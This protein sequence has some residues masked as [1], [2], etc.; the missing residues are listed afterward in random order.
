MLHKVKYIFLI[1]AILLG[2]SAGAQDYVADNM[3]VYQRNVGGWPKHI[4]DVK[5]DYTKKLSESEKAT[6][7][8]DFA[9]ND[10]TI[11]NNATTKEI[12]YLVTAFK[13][14]NNKGYLEAAEKGIRYLLKMQYPNGGFPQFYPDSS[15]YRSQVTFNDNAMINALN[16]L[17]DVIHRAN[18]FEVVS[19]SLIEPAKTAV[20][21]GI[22]C[23][24]K[25]QINVNGNLT[26]WG[27]QYDKRTLKPAK[28][29]I[30]ELP[31][32]ASM[33][34]VEIV[35]FLMKIDKPGKQIQTA[36]NCAV[37]WLQRSKIDGY[38]F[39]DVSDSTQPKG[40][41]R[42]LVLDNNSAVW[43][44]F[45]DI[46][47][48]KPLFAGRD[49]VKRWNLSDIEVERRT[50][51]GWYGKWPKNLLD[52]EY[53]RWV[54]KN[55]S[56]SASRIITVDK[57]GR[58]NFRSIQSAINSLPASIKQPVIIKIGNGVYNEK[59][60]LQKS[61][62]VLQGESREKTIITYAIARDEWRCT[63]PSDWGVATI[64]IAAN[65]ITFK[66][67][68]IINSYGLDNNRDRIIVCPL[69]SIN[70]KRTITKNGHQM[71]LRSMDSSTRL[72]AINV[73]FR[74]YAGDTVSPW[75]TDNGMFYFKDCIMEGGVDFYCPRGW[76]YAE[77]CTFISHTGTAA[78]WHDGSKYE[79]S[80]TV[81]KNCSFKGFDGFNL[82]RYHRDAQFYLIDCSFAKNM[83]DKDIYLV[84]TSNII[85]WGKRVYYSNCKKD[86]GDY[87]WHK[88]NLNSAKGSPSA[89]NINVDWVFKNKWYPET[90]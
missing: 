7:A 39:I 5:V 42:I 73:H 21:K 31:S 77:N 19:S 44:R 62:I 17:W 28:A 82:G 46:E 10:A 67:L 49:G 33:E 6:I 65:D 69:D 83:A 72:K 74:S 35:R 37:K 76:A 71:A 78:I 18:D 52:K 32:I 14:Y 56:Y 43:A 50:G 89:S 88:D 70:K 11:D 23:I 84:P 57:N 38:D 90:N 47:T 26:A 41:D 66:D 20:A 22:D 8:D 51:Y 86:G 45:Y 60:F 29:R 64:N 59:I 48:N 85:Q 15:G 4:G 80:K 40:R 1:A 27:T 30:Y 54:K 9:R 68:T 24:L 53:P 25:T 36:I 79:D 61:N 2:H 34:S 58:G 16:I 75:N 81:L 12:R 55:E 63:Q 87:A 13:K 3:L